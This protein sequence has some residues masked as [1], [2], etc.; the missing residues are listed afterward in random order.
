M[1]GGCK[2]QVYFTEN[3][4][5]IHQIRVTNKKRASNW[6]VANDSSTVILE[7]CLHKYIDSKWSLSIFL[8]HWTD[9]NYVLLKPVV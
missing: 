6:E 2:I 8:P 3:T 4:T 1:T 9:S 5:L 7:Y